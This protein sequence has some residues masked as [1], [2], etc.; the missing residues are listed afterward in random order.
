MWCAVL[1]EPKCPQKL[2]LVGPRVEGEL[3]ACCVGPYATLGKL[4][5]SPVPMLPLNCWHVGSRDSSVDFPERRGVPV[6]KAYRINE[7]VRGSENHF[8]AKWP[9]LWL[10]M[11]LAWRVPK[12]AGNWCNLQSRTILSSY[13]VRVPMAM[14][15]GKVQCL[16][17]CIT[18]VRLAFMTVYGTSVQNTLLRHLETVLELIAVAVKH[19]RQHGFSCKELFGKCITICLMWAIFFGH[20]LLWMTRCFPCASLSWS[21]TIK[22]TV[23]WS[24]LDGAMKTLIA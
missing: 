21:N 22:L 8:K 6:A 11:W 13:S 3:C 12:L 2:T 4:P 18:G 20:S 9:G 23:P 5:A 10:P 17:S 15:S 24:R 16:G 14:M 7:F 1:V 19:K